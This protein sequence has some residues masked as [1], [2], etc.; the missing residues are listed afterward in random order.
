MVDVVD[1]LPTDRAAEPPHH[2]AP[3]LIPGGAPPNL[4]RGGVV[5]PILPLVVS[6]FPL[7][8]KIYSGMSNRPVWGLYPPEVS[9]LERDPLVLAPDKP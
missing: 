2:E 6:H 7:T 3:R 1:V 4:G 8:H 9:E 5:G